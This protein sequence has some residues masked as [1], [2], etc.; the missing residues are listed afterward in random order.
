MTLEQQVV[1]NILSRL[2][3]GQ[4]YRIEVINLIN[5]KFLEFAINFFKK[6]V[7]AK[8]NNETITTDWYRAT[9]ADSKKFKPEDIAIHLGLNKKTIT[10]MH[11]KAPKEIILD[12]SNQHYD[13]L[14]ELIETLIENDN[15]VD[16]TLTIKLK[17]VSVD[18][19][20]N[21]SLIVI[22]TIAVKRAA[23]RGGAW[24]SAGKQTEK[25]LMLTLCKLFSVSKAN[26]SSKEVEKS[27]ERTAKKG[28]T[29]K[30]SVKREIDFFLLNNG[31]EYKCEVKLMG[32][33]NSE[34]ADGVIARDTNVFIADTLSEN[35]KKQLKDL[36]IHWVELR[37]PNGYLTFGDVLKSLGISYQKFE[38]NVDD[39]LSEIFKEIF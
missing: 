37:V 11:R 30:T 34:S 25:L 28:S 21:E 23:L 4:D 33:G 3:K 18:L 31:K 39:K 22:N 1:K 12:A 13:S 19:T 20:M 14:C 9:F 15:E 38:G 17:G 29:K 36:D 27:I 26:Y 32:A 35:N 16:L 5:A 24:S 6:V 8:L 2:I 10:N 7:N